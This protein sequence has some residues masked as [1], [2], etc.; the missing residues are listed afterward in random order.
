MNSRVAVV[1][2]SSSRKPHPPT[3]GCAHE[4]RLWCHTRVDVDSLGGMLAIVVVGLAAALCVEAVEGLLLRLT[5]RRAPQDGVGQ[6][7]ALPPPRGPARPR[8]LRRMA[9]P[10]VSP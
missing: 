2:Y 6:D 10:P 5:R 3:L 4:N 7:P 1:G 9:P 8:R